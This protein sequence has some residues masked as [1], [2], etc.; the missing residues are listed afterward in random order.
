[1]GVTYENCDPWNSGA[2]RE[3]V[4]TSDDSAVARV[5]ELKQS[6]YLAVRHPVFGVGMDN[7]VLFSDSEHA[8]H[9]AYTQV[10]SEVGLT[11]A[12]VYVL[13]IV[14]AVKRLGRIP[15]PR[16]VDKKKRRL[17]YLAIG[18][19]ASLIGYMVSSFFAS[20]AFLW[21]VYYLVGYAVC[22]SR[23][24]DTSLADHTVRVDRHGLRG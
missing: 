6:I 10:A 4:T 18:V 8:T 5:G 16:D 22:V 19:Q 17:P 21:Y 24:W 9:N 12:V 11:A 7:F 3:R 14:A 1:M 23:L 13:F 20:V 15:N 2:Y